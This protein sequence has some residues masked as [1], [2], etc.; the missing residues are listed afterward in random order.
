MADDTELVRELRGE[1]KD[2]GR[3]SLLDAYL[4]GSGLASE[5]YLSTLHSR[6]IPAPSTRALQECGWVRARAVRARVKG[7]EVGACRSL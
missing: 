4:K 2:P 1:V 7:S 5:R 6:G 3:G